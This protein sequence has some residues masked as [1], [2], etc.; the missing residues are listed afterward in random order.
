NFRDQVELHLCRTLPDPSA[1]PS[2][3]EERVLD[4]IPEFLERTGGRAFVLF[5]SYQMMVKATDRL[6]S[7]CAEHDL[8]LLSQS[9]GMP[10]TQMI[11]RFRAAGNAV[12][13]GVD[14]FW[15]GVDVPG[16][17]LGN[18]I[19]TRLPFAVPDRP[20]VAAR[21]EAIEAA[22]GKPFFDYQ[23]PKAVLKL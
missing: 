23:V 9:D 15:Q 2:G 12:L 17:A 18:V 10:R 13:L 16:D 7:W 20:V 11:E 5:T 1:D 3:Y 19:I 21:M 8:P 6:R 22:G 14:S 4:C